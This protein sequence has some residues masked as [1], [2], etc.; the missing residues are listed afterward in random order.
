MKTF[1][2]YN[3]T[4]INEK[5]LNFCIIIFIKK[6]LNMNIAKSFLKQEIYIFAI[7]ISTL[8]MKKNIKFLEMIFQKYFNVICDHHSKNERI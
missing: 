6:F 3:V 5:P 8:I 4:L 7:N 2:N 1:L